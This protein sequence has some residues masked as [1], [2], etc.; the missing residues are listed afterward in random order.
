MAGARGPRPTWHT[1]VCTIIMALPPG[2]QGGEMPHPPGPVG[3]DPARKM[4]PIAP[5]DEPRSLFWSPN[6]PSNILDMIWP[7]LPQG[8]GIGD[9]APWTRD[10]GKHTTISVVWLDWKG[11]HTTISVFWLDWKGNHT[12]ISVVWLDW[13]GNRT[14]INEFW[15]DLEGKPHYD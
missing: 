13:K 4:M 5:R 1:W 15:L 12:T 2:A 3:T 9:Q 14:T 6:R 10:Q 7:N 11:N 8:P